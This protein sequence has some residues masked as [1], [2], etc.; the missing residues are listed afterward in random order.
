MVED[1]EHQALA[2]AIDDRSAGYSR[3]HRLDLDFV[4]TGEFMDAARRRIARSASS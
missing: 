4:T 2:V 3:Q 1:P